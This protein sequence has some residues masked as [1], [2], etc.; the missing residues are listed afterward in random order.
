MAAVLAVGQI[1]LV[2]ARS[3]SGFVH[4]GAP[5]LR[6]FSGLI[7]VDRRYAQVEAVDDVGHNPSNKGTHDRLLVGGYHVPR[8][9]AAACAR[10]R[11]FVDPLEIFEEAPI[12]EIGRR[13]L[14]LLERVVEASEEPPSL[15]VLGYV[16]EEL[17]D[18]RAAPLEMVLEGVDV[19]E[20]LLPKP[21]PVVQTGRQM[22]SDKQFRMDADD[23][24]LLVVRP[25]EDADVAALGKRLDTAPEEVVAQFFGRRH[26]E[27]SDLATLRVHPRED[28]LDGAVLPGGVEGLEDDQHRPG[29]TGKEDLLG[30][31]DLA[32]EGIKCL[33]GGPPVSPF[34]ERGPD[35]L[36]ASRAPLGQ[37]G[38]RPGTDGQLVDQ[39]LW[40]F[41]PPIVPPPAAGARSDSKSTKKPRHP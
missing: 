11:L 39:V 25:V 7:V 17:H 10:G 1:P 20:P 23:Q 14:P 30:S 8:P 35:G 12:D 13:E 27:G 6:K 4:Q 37:T 21:V 16:E 41:H 19:L 2:I 9:P 24:D 26:S 32:L 34:A 15:L 33:L 3:G 40:E 22:L 28:V 31:R 36:R 38:G 18:P 5:G 29:S